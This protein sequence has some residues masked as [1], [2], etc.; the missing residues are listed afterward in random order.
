ME[1]L[2]HDADIG[3][4]EP[5]EPVLVEPGIVGIEH[6][7]ATFRGAFEPGDDH[8][9]RRFAGAARPHHGD[10]VARSHLEVDAAQDGDRTGARGQRHLQI[11]ELDCRVVTLF[12]SVVH[13]RGA[14]ESLTDG[15][16]TGNR[17]G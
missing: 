6:L 8:E 14:I 10:G 12:Q 7:H 2:E 5:G 16:G 3:G 13:G 9:Q 1:G 17:E 4:T 11:F 15:T